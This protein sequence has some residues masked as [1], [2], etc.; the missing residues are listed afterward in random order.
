MP[1]ATTLMTVADFERIPEPSG[2]HYELHHGEPI[3]V[4]PPILEHALIQRKL[5]LLLHQ[6]CTGWF[7]TMEFAFRPLPEYEVWVADVVA[8]RME[9]LLKGPKKAWIS[10]APELVVEILSPSNTAQ[11]M[12]DREQICF[13]GGCQEFWIVDPKLNTVRISTHDGK[14]RTYEQKDEIPLNRFGAAS[15][16]V[17]AVFDPVA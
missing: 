5:M 2:G 4:P 3:L 11:E 10:G 6:L 13:Q 7:V 15:L 1:P 17:A 14:W 8:L 9:R 16:H 12:N